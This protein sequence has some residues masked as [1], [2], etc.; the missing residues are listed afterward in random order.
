M[1]ERRVES[2]RMGEGGRV[3]EGDKGIMLFGYQIGWV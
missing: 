3:G 2:S 1:G